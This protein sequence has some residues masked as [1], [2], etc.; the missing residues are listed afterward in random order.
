MPPRR[1]QSGLPARD[2]F[3][4]DSASLRR[5]DAAARLKPCVSSHPSR[6][7]Q[8]GHS[9]TEASGLACAGARAVA[10]AG[11]DT[12]SIEERSDTISVPPFTRR[13]DVGLESLVGGDRGCDVVLLAGVSRPNAPANWDKSS[14]DH[15]RRV[16]IVRGSQSG[17]GS[18]DSRHRSVHAVDVVVQDLRDSACDE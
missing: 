11:S 15:W 12:S 17:V 14:G 13:K 4:A 1:A 2:G 9:R 3:S 7:R 16:A 5:V 6:S 8:G 18:I 10:S